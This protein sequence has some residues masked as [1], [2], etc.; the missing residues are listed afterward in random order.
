MIDV[1]MIK[2]HSMVWNGNRI[3]SSPWSEGRDSRSSWGDPFPFSPTA[4]FSPQKRTSSST[5]AATFTSFAELCVAGTLSRA[6]LI[7]L[8]ERNQLSFHLSILYNGGSLSLLRLRG[9]EG[10]TPC[11]WVMDSIWLRVRR[12]TTVCFLLHL[13]SSIQRIEQSIRH[14]SQWHPFLP[15]FPSYS[16]CENCQIQYA[17][18]MRETPT[19][20][21]TR[22]NS[23]S[24]FKSIIRLTIRCMLAERIEPPKEQP[25]Y[26]W[27]KESACVT[28]SSGYETW[29]LSIAFVSTSISCR[30]TV[31]YVLCLTVCAVVLD[32]EWTILPAK[33]ALEVH[34]VRAREWQHK[35]RGVPLG[36]RN[37][38]C[39]TGSEY[40]SYRRG[41]EL[42]KIGLAWCTRPQI[43][44][45]R[46]KWDCA[47]HYGGSKR[48]CGCFAVV[49][50]VDRRGGGKRR[51]SSNWRRGQQYRAMV[52]AGARII[53]KGIGAIWKGLEE[54]LHNRKPVVLE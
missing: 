10:T 7:F 39:T 22:R 5:Q 12:F 51:W 3:C 25:N 47:W 24:H 46:N 33:L 49:T 30:E 42:P 44:R 15:R 31:E 53:P 26:R 32:L 2:N 9:W 36:N 28:I 52:C 40:C 16:V 18:L 43:E 19:T 20:S 34:D 11:V 45:R 21:S 37:L 48:S 35:S 4:R 29:I 17:L 6:A 50:A 8:T 54:D 41:K 23:G 27:F 13:I 1:C 38:N 14:H